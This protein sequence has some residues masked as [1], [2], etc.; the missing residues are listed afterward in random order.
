MNKINEQLYECLN[1]ILCSNPSEHGCQRGPR[2]RVHVLGDGR[3]V[4]L[5]A[6]RVPGPARAGVPGDPR[7]RPPPA[8]RTTA[9]RIRVDAR[10]QGD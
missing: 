5:A 7:A 3:A 8:L 6:A 1:V 4:S 2:A 10:V 9:Q